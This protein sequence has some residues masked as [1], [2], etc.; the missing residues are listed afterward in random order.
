MSEPSRLSQQQPTYELGA[1]P[2][3]LDQLRAAW[4]P[5]IRQGAIVDATR[6]EASLATSVLVRPLLLA[7]VAKLNEI[8]GQTSHLPAD[9]ANAWTGQTDISLLY[10]A[11]GLADLC[12]PAAAYE[13]EISVSIEDFRYPDSLETVLDIWTDH[14]KHDRL[15]EHD[16]AVLTLAAIV[17]DVAR[18]EDAYRKQRE[19]G[20]QSRRKGY[21]RERSRFA[22]SR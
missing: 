7:L 6:R 20:I 10:I 19:H 18:N 2:I 4:M 12:N 13:P 8:V 14:L 16:R 1:T 22:R 11:R 21:L 5:L 3:T 15:V 9:S 17:Q